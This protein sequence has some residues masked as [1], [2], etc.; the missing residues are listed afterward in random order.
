MYICG[1]TGFTKQGFDPGQ[2][3]AE[4]EDARVCPVQ[5]T[6]SSS[7]FQQ[8]HDDT[9][10]TISEAGGA[11]VKTYLRKSKNVQQSVREKSDKYVK[12]ATL[13]TPRSVKKEGEEVLQVLSHKRCPVPSVQ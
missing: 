10:E 12:E 11:S 9:A 3:A 7:W 1:C 4:V 6:T 13:Q 2:G 8:T 5:Y